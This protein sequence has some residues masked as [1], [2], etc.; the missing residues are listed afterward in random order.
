MGKNGELYL[1]RPAHI[2]E[3]GNNAEG[4]LVILHGFLGSKRNLSS[5]SKLFSQDLGIPVRALLYL[6]QDLCSHT[7]SPHALPVTYTSMAAGLVPVPKLDSSRYRTGHEEDRKHEA[8]D[9]EGGMASLE[10]VRS[11]PRPNIVLSLSF[12]V[13]VTIN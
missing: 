11:A 12:D 8:A 4:A 9:K 2:P 6:P 13:T 3:N 1:A 7:S 5:L 10:K